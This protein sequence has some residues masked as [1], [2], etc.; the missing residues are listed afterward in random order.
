L[1]LVLHPRLKPCFHYI[2]HDI[3]LIARGILGLV[4][5]VLVVGMLLGLVVG[6]LATWTMNDI[7]MRTRLLISAVCASCIGLG[8]WTVMR[9]P[10]KAV[11]ATPDG[12]ATRERTATRYNFARRF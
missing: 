12:G 11:A 7:S 8:I 9:P 5:L 10:I 4:G 1:C 2:L 3:A 6:L